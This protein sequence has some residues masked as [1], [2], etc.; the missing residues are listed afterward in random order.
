MAEQNRRPVKAQ[1]QFIHVTQC[2]T[3]NDFQRLDVEIRL[4]TPV[5]EDDA[6][7]ASLTE[8]HGDVCGRAEEL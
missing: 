6:S 3:R 4:I 8:P 7:R 5:E 1:Q 2:Q